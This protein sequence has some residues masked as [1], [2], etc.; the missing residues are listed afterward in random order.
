MPKSFYKNAGTNFHILHIV[1]ATAMVGL[2][3]FLT[4]HYFE[5]KYPEGIGTSS[6]LCNYSSFI[7][8]DITT[9][10]NIS[11]IFGVPISIFG[12]LMGIWLLTGYFFKSKQM[13]GTNHFL[14]IANAIICTFLTAYSFIFLKGFCP[15]CILYYL[16]SLLA[17][18]VYFKT[19][20]LRSPSWKTLG[21]YALSAL[22]LAGSTFAYNDH[23]K[24]DMNKN[25]A[26]LIKYYDQLASV[27]TPK[28][29]APYFLEKNSDA[30][31]QLFKFSDFQCP[32]CRTLSDSLHKIAIKYKGEINV[33]YLFYPLDNNCNPEVTKSFHA[34]ACEAAY[35]ASC[36]PEKFKQVEADIF[37]N[38]ESL[39]KK[40]IA[41]YAKKENVYNCYNAPSTKEKV[42]QI[43]RKAN[44]Y[45]IK[46]T[47]TLIINNK[48]IDRMVPLK[49]LYII[50]DEL[51]E[52]GKKRLHRS[53]R[54]MP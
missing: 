25:S 35:L 27:E 15:L 23:K 29:E 1:S 30:P 50:L 53:G 14:L 47:P 43:I 40:W 22:I 5:A 32:A 52:R 7:S 38:Q 12:F 11:N 54:N 49:Y 19:S 8:C 42:V 18:F 3:L 31:L 46:G 34:L 9:F 21:A 26:Q 20:H 4:F 33:Q 44:P 16:S 48:K 2:S 41:D 45:Q 39:S 28:I 10:S 17:F 24:S 51:L 6:G 13:E 37:D 36:L